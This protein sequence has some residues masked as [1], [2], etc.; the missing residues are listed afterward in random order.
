M[1]S[2][3]GSICHYYT[4]TTWGPTFSRALTSERAELVDTTGNLIE[5]KLISKAQ[6]KNYSPIQ[7]NG[8]DMDGIQ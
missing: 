1:L 4:H 2:L 5:A 6:W 7:P 8:H 3:A